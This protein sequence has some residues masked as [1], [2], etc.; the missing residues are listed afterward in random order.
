MNPLAKQDNDSL[1]KGISTIV[2]STSE[3]TPVTCDDKDFCLS[4]NDHEISYEESAQ[5][6]ESIKHS[7]NVQIPDIIVKSSNSSSYLQLATSQLHSSPSAAIGIGIKRKIM[8]LSSSSSNSLAANDTI[9]IMMGSSSPVKSPRT[10]RS[11]SDSNIDK[12]TND[13]YIRRHHLSNTHFDNRSKDDEQ[14]SFTDTTRCETLDTH[15]VTYQSV[16]GQSNDKGSVYNNRKLTRYLR[17][18]LEHGA[19]CNFKS[20]DNQECSH[21]MLLVLKNPNGIY[22]YVVFIDHLNS[23][24]DEYSSD[25]GWKYDTIMVEER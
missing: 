9:A 25:V 15:P 6:S 20:T 14:N 10:S 24:R 8:S 18:K 19:D 5:I 12:S 2:S 3:A 16:S 7:L 1:Q 21:G 4:T 23:G 17:R 13:E 11:Y 22:I